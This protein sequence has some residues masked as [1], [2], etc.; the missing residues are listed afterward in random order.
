MGSTLT[1]DVAEIGRFKVMLAHLLRC[2]ECAKVAMLVTQACA[3]TV[4]EERP[5]ARLSSVGGWK[6][7]RRRG[8]ASGCEGRRP[9]PQDRDVS[10]SFILLPTFPADAA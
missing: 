2:A 6:G 3:A 10:T 5:P 9:M 7:S 1:H 4:V 8:G